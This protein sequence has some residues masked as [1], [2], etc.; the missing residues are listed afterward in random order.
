MEGEE[1]CL[2]PDGLYVDVDAPMG[3]VENVDEHL[4]EMV[5]GRVKKG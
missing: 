2:T 5:A 3:D 1:K 4:P